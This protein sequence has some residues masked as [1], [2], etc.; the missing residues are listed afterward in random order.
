[1]SEITGKTGMNVRSVIET[2]GDYQGITL[3]ERIAIRHIFDKS[4]DIPLVPEQFSDI[5]LPNGPTK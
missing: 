3:D 4:E 5:L 2:E 1:V